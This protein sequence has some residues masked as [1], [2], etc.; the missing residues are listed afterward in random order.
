MLAH[1]TAFSRI[2]EE[3]NSSAGT[4][5]LQSF[6]PPAKHRKHPRLPVQGD[7]PVAPSHE[8]AVE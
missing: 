8:R 7:D 1:S 5:K 2:D 3:S 4:T 6:Q